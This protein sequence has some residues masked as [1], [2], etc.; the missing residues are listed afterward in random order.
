MP[1]ELF[2]IHLKGEYFLY[3]RIKDHSNWTTTYV[4]INNQIQTLKINVLNVF[5]QQ[6]VIQSIQF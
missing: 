4:Y 5:V 2:C 6:L 1:N 3:L